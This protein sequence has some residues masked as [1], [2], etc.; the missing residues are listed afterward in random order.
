MTSYDAIVVGTGGMGSA[1]VYHI[2]RRGLRVLG[3]DRFG[4]AH[5]RGSS[6]GQS[7]MIR[8]AY[9][10]HPDYVPLL[11]SAYRLWVELEQTAGEQLYFQTG[12]VQCGPADGNVLAGVL[13]SARTHD[14]TVD[15]LTADEIE[16]RWPGFHVPE[17]MAGVYE[18][19]SGYLRVEACVRQHLAAAKRHGATLQTDQA[20]V[21]W[22]SE[23]EHI[24][25]RTEND[26][27]HA[28]RLIITAGAWAGQILS[29]LNIPLEVQKKTLFWFDTNSDIYTAERGFPGF[30]F[31]RPDGIY[32]GFPQIDPR[33]IKVG[34]HRTNQ[35]A[36]TIVD[37]PTHVDQSIDTDLESRVT[38][39]L[40]DHLPQAFARCTASTVCMY[41][42]PPDEHFVVDR[43]PADSRVVFAAGMSGHGF[44]FAPVLGEA[45]AD[46]A[47]DGQTDH[48]IDFLRCGRPGLCS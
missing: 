25:V 3:L 34:E 15:E 33:G 35:T 16:A 26:V 20:V 32:Y 46:L 14:L 36:E 6:H 10:E 24:A 37:D 47:F 29:D 45:L 48:A 30:L 5:D 18:A 44:K 7:R 2:A 13:K 4:A 11:K 39:F 12:L 21:D 8:Q 42:M 38:R 1:A 40:G 41:T 23:P 27:F 17:D 28:D 9:F 19:E 43:H 22:K 31:E